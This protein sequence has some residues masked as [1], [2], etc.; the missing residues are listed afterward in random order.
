MSVYI[1]NVYIVYTN[2]CLIV[3]FA[4]LVDEFKFSRENLWKIFTFSEFSIIFKYI[5]ICMYT[6]GK[7]SYRIDLCE[8]YAFK[9]T[10]DE[11]NNNIITKVF[12]LPTLVVI[13]SEYSS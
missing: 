6:Q 2:R 1:Y 8:I 5:N 9:Y 13:I 12:F 4:S 11:H 7:S 3:I 10:I